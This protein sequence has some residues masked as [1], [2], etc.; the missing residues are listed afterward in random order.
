MF[1][2]YKRERPILGRWPRD[3]QK[4]YKGNRGPGK[5]IIPLLAFL[6]ARLLRYIHPHVSRYACVDAP[7]RQTIIRRNRVELFLTV[8]LILTSKKLI[9]RPIYVSSGHFENIS[10]RRT[11]YISQ[12]IAEPKK[13]VS[14][15]PLPI[16]WVALLRKLRLSHNDSRRKLRAAFQN[17]SP[18]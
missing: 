9:C 15:S 4:T 5:K 1:S 3:S 7:C 17:R 11:G 13:R 6:M 18:G 8:T 14:R 10:V 16:L 12:S 2:K